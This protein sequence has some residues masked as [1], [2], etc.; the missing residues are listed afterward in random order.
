MAKV[1]L[2]T[3]HKTHHSQITHAHI[4]T[5]I[6]TY[7]RIWCAVAVRC[8]GDFPFVLY[9]VELVRDAAKI[10]CMANILV[11]SSNQ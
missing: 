2:S 7:V 3:I 6:Y 9:C 4:H 10:I 1:K 5:N 8:C 11:R